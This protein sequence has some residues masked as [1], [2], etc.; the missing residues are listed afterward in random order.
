[1]TAFCWDCD[2]PFDA[3]LFDFCPECGGNGYIDDYDTEDEYD[4]AWWAV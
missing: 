1:V 3:D 4:D 2:E